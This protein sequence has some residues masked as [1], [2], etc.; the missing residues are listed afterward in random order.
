MRRQCTVG[1]TGLSSSKRGSINWSCRCPQLSEELEL[2]GFDDERGTAAAL[3]TEAGVRPTATLARVNGVVVR[4]HTELRGVLAEAGLGARFGFTAG[5]A[6]SSS[7]PGRSGSRRGGGLGVSALSTAGG[8]RGRLSPRLRARR[9]VAKF[10]QQAVAAGSP[11]EWMA[12]LWMDFSRRFGTDP[13][14]HWQRL[15][16]ARTIQA[17]ARERRRRAAAGI[18]TPARSWRSPQLR[19]R[20]PRSPGGGPQ[21]RFAASPIAQRAPS[22]RLTA[23]TLSSLARAEEEEELPEDEW[24][25]SAGTGDVGSQRYGADRY[26]DDR[27]DDGRYGEGR[28]GQHGGG[29]RPVIPG[30]SARRARSR[31]ALAE[32]QAALAAPHRPARVVRGGGQSAAAMVSRLRQDRAKVKRGQRLP[33]ERSS[34][35]RSPSPSRLER[36]LQQAVGGGGQRS[37]VRGGSPRPRDERE[38]S[39]EAAA[40]ALF[41]D[42]V[43]RLETDARSLELSDGH[44]QPE[45]QRL[46]LERQRRKLAEAQQERWRRQAEVERQQQRLEYR[47]EMEQ[48]CMCGHVCACACS[49]ICLG[50]GVHIYVQYRKCVCV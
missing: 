39:S 9:C 38:E 49:C 37:W 18:P 26:E 31:Q 8:D 15:V 28:Y 44:F 4:S 7:S 20:S 46:S 24:K 40:L 11:S 13:R 17:H 48:T 30:E 29:A 27:Y 23:P 3:C 43:G 14:D 42:A 47:Q 16:A 1:Q 32:H 22:P 45:Q 12:M 2:L 5:A 36:E 6:R 34:R 21:G 10:K 41:A 25:L 19:S 33:S 35:S 50:V